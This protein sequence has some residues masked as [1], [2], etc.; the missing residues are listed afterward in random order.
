M[1]AF[2]CIDELDQ[3][4]ERYKENRQVL[5]SGLPTEFLGNVAPCDGAFYIYADVSH[6]TNDSEIFCRRCL[7]ENGVAIPNGVDIDPKRGSRVVIFSF[8]V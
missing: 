8:D 5:L 7:D 6:M 3:H 4:V 1:K 2:D